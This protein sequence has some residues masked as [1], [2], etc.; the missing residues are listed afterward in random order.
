MSDQVKEKITLF[1]TLKSLGGSYNA[2]G[3]KVVG[4]K[5]VGIT[6]KQKKVLTAADDSP[7]KTFSTEKA[8][9]DYVEKLS[10]K[11]KKK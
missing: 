5:V 7:V 8:A 4:G 3:A 6:E 10:N 1:A 2:A 9:T 11:G